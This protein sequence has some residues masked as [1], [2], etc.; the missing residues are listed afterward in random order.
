LPTKW[1]E[2]LDL[3]VD[4]SLSNRW[5]NLDLDYFYIVIV[6]CIYFV[7]FKFYHLGCWFYIYS[8]VIGSVCS[9]AEGT[10]ERHLFY[11]FYLFSGERWHLSK[12]NIWTT[13]LRALY[14]TQFNLSC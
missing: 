8:F 1:K 13:A 11:L 14:C 3:S 6:C 12:K 10:G 7:S 4:Q 9:S 5:V 2:D